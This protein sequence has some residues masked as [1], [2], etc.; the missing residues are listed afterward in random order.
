MK[1]CVARH[2]GLIVDGR[3]YVYR[4]LDPIRATLSIRHAMEHE[5]RELSLNTQSRNPLHAVAASSWYPD[6]ARGYCNS[7]IASELKEKLFDA[8]FASMPGVCAHATPKIYPLAEQDARQ[9]PLMTPKQY[10]LFRECH[11]AFNP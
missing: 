2:A 5:P 3:S 11:A 6:E 7:E 8:L 9:L 1:S 10:N 4:A